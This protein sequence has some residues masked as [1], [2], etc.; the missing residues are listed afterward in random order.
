M[1][2]YRTYPDTVFRKLR[3]ARI[4]VAVADVDIVVRIPC[5][6]GFTVERTRIP[7]RIPVRVLLAALDK[8]LSAGIPREGD[9][10]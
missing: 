8:A 3:E 9:S 4:A 1:G 6:V 2:S 5:D 7:N 10:I